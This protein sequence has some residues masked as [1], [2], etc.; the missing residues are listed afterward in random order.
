MLSIE[1]I[2][3][4]ERKNEINVKQYNSLLKQ[5]NIVLKQNKILSDALKE[6]KNAAIN[7][8]KLGIIV[9]NGWLEQKIDEVLN[10]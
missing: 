1:E 8:I 5:Y 6:I 3:E 10:D 2:N 9:S 4:L 7:N